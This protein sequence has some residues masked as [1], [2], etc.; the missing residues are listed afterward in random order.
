MELYFP[1]ENEFSSSGILPDKPEFQIKDYR[2][3]GVL[4]YLKT[5]NNK[6]FSSIVSPAAL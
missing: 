3:N 5:V 4:V 6:L 2:I 1:P